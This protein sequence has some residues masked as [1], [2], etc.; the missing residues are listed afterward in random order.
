VMT[1]RLSCRQ[2]SCAVSLSRI[3]GRDG[4][5]IWNQT[6]E[7]PTGEPYLLAAA[8]ERYVGKEY[9]S[10]G[11]RAGARGLAVTPPDFKQYLRLRRDLAGDG[12]GVPFP[13][14]LAEV[15]AL[16]AGSPRFLEGALLEAA[17]LGR[18]YTAGRDPANLDRAFAVLGAAQAMAPADPRPLYDEIAVALAGRR[19]ERAQLAI[20][21]LARLQPGEPEILVQRAHLLDRRGQA[22]QGLE[23]LREAARLRPSW[24]NLTDLAG[25]ESRLGS[26]AAARAHLLQARA[27]LTDPATARSLRRDSSSARSPL[28]DAAAA[29][30]PPPGR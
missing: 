29:P 10:R 26:S 5:L 18:R 2:D 11:S 19:W 7:I 8:V 6:L 27:R 1:S 28:V 22:R 4:S 21:A 15:R 3:S 9:A 13:A 16:R 12:R 14:R 20:G 30:S 24:T 23:L 17:L 25:L